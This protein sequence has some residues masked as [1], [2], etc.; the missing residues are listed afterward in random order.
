[1]VVTPF[2]YLGTSMN[3]VDNGAAGESL[4]QAEVKRAVGLVEAAQWFL[5]RD[6]HCLLVI[7]E[8]FR[9]TSPDRAEEQTYDFALRFAGF[10]STLY[11]L[12]THFVARV[13]Q[14]ETQ[15]KGIC[16]N[17]KME[18]KRDEQGKLIRTFKLVEGVNTSNVAAEI[19]DNAFGKK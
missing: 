18:V 4:Y 1:M 3:I 16:K 14:L 6:Q 2:A 11:I 13:T 8:L 5:D 12:A 10:E 17:H 9:G 19:L 15:T 7:D